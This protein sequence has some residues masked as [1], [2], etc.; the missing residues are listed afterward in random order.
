MTYRPK[1]PGYIGLT[2]P[3]PTYGTAEWEQEKFKIMAA[4][5]DLVALY[6]KRE[7]PPKPRPW[8]LPRTLRS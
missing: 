3:P 6:P 7:G 4:V 1:L 8:W 5:D 2:I